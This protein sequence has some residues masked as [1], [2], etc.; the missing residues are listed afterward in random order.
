MMVSN[1]FFLLLMTIQGLLRF[2]CYLKKA[3]HFLCWNPF[4]YTLLLSFIL[5]FRSLGLIMVRSLEIIMQW[6]FINKSTSYIRFFVQTLHSKMEW[7]G[8]N[9]NIFLE[10]ARAM[11]FQSRGDCILTAT[12]L[13]NRL[14]NSVLGFKI[15]YELLFNTQP[16]YTHLKNF[17]CLY[18]LSTLKHGRTK[19]E[20][21][22][23]SCVFLGYLI[24]KKAY[25]CLLYTSPSPRD[26]LLSRMP[27]SA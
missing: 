12:Y 2:S 20:A 4:L 14:L 27:S 15:P 22:A 16:T 25:N 8:E 24:N 7:W 17:G 9:I 13:V 5:K 11:M 3:M 10:V 23:Q 18:F 26:G 21:R 1:V 6:H 19:F